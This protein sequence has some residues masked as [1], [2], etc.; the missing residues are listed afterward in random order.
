MQ[1]NTCFNVP[2][3]SVLPYTL[4][5][6]PKGNVLP[7]TLPIGVTL[8][9]PIG[10][11]LPNT[12]PIDLIRS[13]TQALWESYCLIRFLLNLWETYWAIRFLLGHFQTFSV[14]VLNCLHVRKYYTNRNRIA[15]YASYWCH[16]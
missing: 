3:G 2:I 7:Y 8:I 1:D 15:Q 10:V 14:L 6:N 12:L 9:I 5:I 13:P 11:V 4:H 16:I